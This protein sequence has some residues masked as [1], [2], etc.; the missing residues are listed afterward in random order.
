[1]LRYLEAGSGTPVVLV[2]GNFACKEWWRGLLEDPPPGARLLAPDLPGFGE[3]PAPEGFAPSIPA[4]A[5]ALQDFLRAV[6]AEEAVLVGHSLGGAVAMEAAE[7]R[8]RGLVLL[9]SAPP[10]GLLTPEAYY[11]VLES[12]RQDRKALERALEAMAPT[13]RPPWFPELVDCA[14]RMHPAHYQGN[15]RALA[16]WRASRAYGGPV[17]VL[18]GTLDPLISREMAEATAAFFPKAR[19]QVLEG[20]GH[21]LNLENPGLLKAILEGFLKEVAG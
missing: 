19:L 1:M 6:G 17:L 11:P 12:Y 16:L 7:E 4:Y 20:V 3:S 14:Q 8:T 10:S 2:H 13:Q 18:Y 15:A 21:S 9:N 5:L